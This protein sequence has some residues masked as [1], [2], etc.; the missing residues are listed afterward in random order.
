MHVT[1]T[2]TTAADA[3]APAV[4][5]AGETRPGAL[6]TILPL[7][8]CPVDGAELIWDRVPSGLSCR[9]GTHFFPIEADIPRLLVP[10]QG[11]DIVKE[12]YETTPFPNYDQLDTRDS[13]R[14][15]AGA[16][17][18]GR[19]LDEQISHTA[20]VLE[21]GC[22]TG[23]MTNFLGMSWGRTVI[24]A[25]CC[26]NSL[27]LA[28]EFRDRFGINNSYFS[29]VNLF[30]LPFARASFDVVISN[31][32]PI[33]PAIA[34]APSSQLRGSSSLAESSSFDCI[35]GWGACRL[36]GGGG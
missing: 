12:F 9:H 10:N 1:A 2:T 5:F 25:D 21:V 34:P 20:S 11:P 27:K 29:Q 17:V 32:V 22:G 28:K 16:L 6:H 4:S 24:G 7:L 23:Q 13:L 3:Q 19:M 15:K 36:C 8:R 31:E 18:F 26:L 14:R 33:V 35:T 30:Q